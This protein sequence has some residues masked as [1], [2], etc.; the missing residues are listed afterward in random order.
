MK[1]F[2][3]ARGRHFE[4]GRANTAQTWRKTVFM[5]IFSVEE[6]LNFLEFLFMNCLD[7]FLNCII[8]K[9]GWIEIR[10]WPFLYQRSIIPLGTEV[11]LANI[12]SASGY[13]SRSSSSIKTVTR[14]IVRL[15]ALSFQ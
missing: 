9:P 13:A 5:W 15:D 3:I 11:N 2:S 4:G 12:C 7:R 1:R 6:N 10:H 14:R 8:D